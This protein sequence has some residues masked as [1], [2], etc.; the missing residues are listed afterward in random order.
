MFGSTP[1]GTEGSLNLMLDGGSTDIQLNNDTTGRDGV[2]PMYRVD[3]MKYG[4]HQLVGHISQ[5]TSGAFVL[6]HLECA[7]PLFHSVL[8]TMH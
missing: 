3:N 4:D 1:N 5:L 2:T 6:D 8:R 7:T